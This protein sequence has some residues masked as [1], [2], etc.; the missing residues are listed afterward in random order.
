MPEDEL[1]ASAK[2]Q[3]QAAARLRRIHENAGEDI[4]CPVMTAE[5]LKAVSCNIADG[6]EAVLSLMETYGM[7]V[8]NDVCTDAENVAME[9]MWKDDLLT[10]AAPSLRE[11][12]EPSIRKVYNAVKEEGPTQW[13]SATFFNDTG[14]HKNGLV[15]GSYAW[16]ARLHPNVKKVYSWLNDCEEEEM[17]VGTDVVFFNP[18]ELSPD[19]TIN[20]NWMHVDD[21]EKDIINPSVQGVLYTW[22]AESSNSSTT[23]IW[24]GSH[25]TVYPKLTSLMHPGGSHFIKHNAI[26][27][28]DERIK[29]LVDGSK[30]A[31]RIPVPAGSLLLWG[32]KTSHQG[33]A[34][35]RRLAVP[36]CWEK[37]VYRDEAA[38]RRKMWLCATGL[39]STHWAT[40]GKVHVRI[41]NTTSMQT[42]ITEATDDRDYEESYH[43]VRLPCYPSLLPYPIRADKIDE[44]KAAV[45]SLWGDTTAGAAVKEFTD[46]TIVEGILKEEVLKAL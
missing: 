32:S 21:N 16:A 18:R 15:Q 4:T 12:Y 42:E 23:V 30:Y 46:K 38:L 39:P 13:P 40:I 33:W 5:E 35:G 31:R 19:C 7:A 9:A 43:S 20:D 17:C 2:R 34:G 26:L 6:A 41:K 1:V 14:S 22:S 24:P 44:W 10:L 11:G 29:T 25:K 28:K 45:P 3:E 8:V 27:D 36:V 37:K